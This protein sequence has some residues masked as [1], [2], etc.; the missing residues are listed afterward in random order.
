[1]PGTGN[2]RAPVFVIFGLRTAEW[3]WQRGRPPR[4]GLL[5]W[6]ALYAVSYAAFLATAF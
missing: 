4:I 6:A 3:L 1:V 5:A 2:V